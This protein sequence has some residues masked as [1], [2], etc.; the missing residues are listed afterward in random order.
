MYEEKIITIENL[1][2]K[3]SSIRG[4]KKLVA[5]SGSFDILHV[6]HISYL[7]EAKSQG[8]FLIVFLNS[9]ISI[10]KYKGKNRPVIPLHQRAAFLAAFEF[11][12]YVVPFDDL[13]PLSVLEQLKP[14]VFCNGSDWGENPIERDFVESYGGKFKIVSSQTRDQ[15]SSSDIIR[16]AHS[17]HQT[18]SPRVIFLDRDGVLITDK[19]YLH[20]IE[21][22]EI[23]PETI[24]GLVKLRD[25]GWKFIVITN[26]SGIGRKMFSEADMN[27]VH[28]HISSLLSGY[29]LTIEKFYFCPHLPEDN[30]NCR[31]PRTG[32]LETAADEFDVALAKSWFIGDKLSDIEAGRRANTKTILMESS[33]TPSK[34]TSLTQPDTIVKN[35]DDAA[36]YIN[37]I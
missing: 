13:N 29:N 9:D 7:M 14:E 5:C 17:A 33:D 35:L 6:G 22:M 18:N 12:D 26:Q 8:D 34:F 10:Q 30:C 20:K 19:G 11:V 16:R 3:L 28:E 25:R 1:C 23:L 37:S 24:S 32:L 2:Q 21:D 15:F 27:S 31:K 4:Q 36:E